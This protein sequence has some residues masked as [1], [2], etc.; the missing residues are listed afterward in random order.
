MPT[1]EGR[2][3]EAERDPEQDPQAAGRGRGATGAAQDHDGGECQADRAS[4]QRRVA[5]EQQPDQRHQRQD[6]IPVAAQR[7][8]SALGHSSR[9]RPI[10]PALAGLQVH[11][12]ERGAE[13]RAAPG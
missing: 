1:Q 11:H 8:R 2:R 9:G 6:Q 7:A 3:G 4:E 13:S 5:G 12:P 10:R